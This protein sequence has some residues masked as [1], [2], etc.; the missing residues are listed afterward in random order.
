M[1]RVAQREKARD[2]KKKQELKQKVGLVEETLVIIS[3][4]MNGVA[5]TI[6]SQRG[7]L[8]EYQSSI[9]FNEIFVF[10]YRIRIQ[11]PYSGK[12]Y[13]K[14]MSVKMGRFREI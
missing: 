7:S 4:R 14:I 13:Q 12:L 2:Q 5:M 11:K 1:K 3:A 8:G 9:F 6:C 10:S